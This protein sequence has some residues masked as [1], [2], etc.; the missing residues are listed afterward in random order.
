M[1]CGHAEEQV[2]EVVHHEDLEDAGQHHEQFARDPRHRS[3]PSD[4]T[5][6][7]RLNSSGNLPL[8]AEKII[9][10]VLLEHGVPV[11]LSCGTTTEK[12]SNTVIALCCCTRIGCTSYSRGRFDP[13]DCW[14]G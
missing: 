1:Q 7:V 6:A 2:Y 5:F 14:T 10:D 12:D 13:I 3:G 4:G 11:D 8:P 9:A